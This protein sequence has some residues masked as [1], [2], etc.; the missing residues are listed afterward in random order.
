LVVDAAAFSEECWRVGLLTGTIFFF[1]FIVDVED[2]FVLGVAVESLSSERNERSSP[3][4]HE[5]KKSRL[6]KIVGW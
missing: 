1:F 4:L 2:S 6:C 3:S 5:S